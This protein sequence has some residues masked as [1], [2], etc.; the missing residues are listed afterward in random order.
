[1]NLEKNIRDLSLR[2]IAFLVVMI[3]LWAIVLMVGVS[4]NWSFLTDKIESTFYLGGFIAGLLIFALSFMNI[5]ASLTI[6]SKSQNNENLDSKGVGKQ[7]GIMLLISSALISL[8]VGG[9]WYAEWKVYESVSE[10]A[11]QKL[12]VIS[13]KKLVNDLANKIKNDSSI[14]EIL[15][16]RDALS[17]DVGSKE[18][19]SIIIP[20][21]RAGVKIY[22]EITPWLSNSDKN[23]K[24]SDVDL[25]RFTLSK[26]EESDFNKLTKG[27][28]DSF[29][30][31]LADHKLRIFYRMIL[32]NQEIILLLDTSRQSSRESSI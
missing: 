13:E 25:D 31:S 28:T 9:L 19:I 6:I 2:L 7:F 16:I 14:D 32:D 22:Y 18:T 21:E 10:E 27:E 23:K 29:K 11:W 8:I 5:T 12:Q 30:I 26:K 20:K 4:F 24:L 3:V 15:A 1:M 17:N